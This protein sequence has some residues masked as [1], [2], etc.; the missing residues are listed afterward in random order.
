MR[1][2]AHTNEGC[3]CC[4]LP[5]MVGWAFSHGKLMPYCGMISVSSAR[6]GFCFYNYCG[7][8][9]DGLLAWLKRSKRGCDCKVHGEVI[10]L[11]TLD[12]KVK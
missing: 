12:Y 5:W 8:S 11:M 10:C 1:A 7:M 2:D 9:V 4:F 3:F 6:K